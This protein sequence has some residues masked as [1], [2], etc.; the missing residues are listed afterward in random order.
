MKNY[1]M[2]LWRVFSVFAV[3]FVSE[4]LLPASAQEM[5]L[6]DKTFSATASEHGFHYFPADSSSSANW[7]EPF[8]YFEGIF[9]IRYE[10]MDYPS[11]ESFMLSLCIWSDIKLNKKNGWETW[12]ETCSPQL[13][14]SGRGIFTTVTTPATW[15]SIHKDE[16]VD[17]ARVKDFLR[18]GIVHWCANSKNLSDWSTDEKGCWP[19]HNLLLPMKMRV[20]VIAVAKGYEFSGWK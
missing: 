4:L 17:F 14:I 15:W 7:L 16:P 2:N 1:L 11:K 5:C 10:I 9:H 8:N 3:I 20:T 6:F 13:A 18:L 19:Q 12:K